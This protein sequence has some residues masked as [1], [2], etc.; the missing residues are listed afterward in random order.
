[1]RFGFRSFDERRIE[2][3]PALLDLLETLSQIQGD[4]V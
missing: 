2:R 3:A 4:L 1:V